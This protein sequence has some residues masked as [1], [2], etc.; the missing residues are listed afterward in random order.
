MGSTGGPFEPELIVFAAL[1]IFIIWKLRSVLGVRV[2]RDAPP[3][4]HLATGRAAPPAAASFHAPTRPSP[5]KKA[6][7][8]SRWAGVADKDSAGWAGLDAIALGDP[9]FDGL[10]FISG[11]RRAYEM[12][13]AAFARGDRAALQPLLSEATFEGF[14]S[15]IRRREAAGETLE[16]AIVAIDGM[17]VVSAR[18]QPGLNE[19]VLR[20]EARLLQ[21]RRDRDGQ[22]IEGGRTIP[23]IEIWTF[24]RDPRAADPNWK[25]VA[26]RPGD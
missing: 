21:I 13:V 14:E 12:I 17:K 4:S 6:E 8:E 19:I 3:S 22:T 5:E 1:A 24:A 2:D 16:T 10:A 7:A 11:A 20:I 26:T 9:G 18:A 15:E 23:V 25:L